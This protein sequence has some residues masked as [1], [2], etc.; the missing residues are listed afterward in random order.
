MLGTQLFTELQDHGE[1]ACVE[2]YMR[3]GMCVYIIYIYSDEPDERCQGQSTV[4]SL[5]LEQGSL[6]FY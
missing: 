6:L 5:G 1:V 3:V 4:A 2:G